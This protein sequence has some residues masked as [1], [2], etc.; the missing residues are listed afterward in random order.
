M[1]NESNPRVSIIIPVYNGSDYLREAI[2]SA[3]GQ[4]YRNI[5]V[6]VINDGSC[7]KG[8][9]EALAKSFG[10][11]IKYIYKENGGVAT[12]LN[13]G[14]VAAQ[15][16]YISWLSHD[17]VYMPNKVELQVALLAESREPVILYSDYYWID[18]A[19]RT[20]GTCRIPR[21]L[22]ELMVQALLTSYPVNGCTTLIPRSCF[23]AEGLFNDTL[24]TTQDYEM[25]FRLARRFKFIHLPYPLLKSRLHAKQGSQTINDVQVSE[26]HGLY[27]WVL[28]NFSPET[29]CGLTQSTL[30]GCYTKLASNFK[31]RSYMNAADRSFDLARRHLKQSKGIRY[32]YD[33]TTI[34]LDTILPKYA[35]FQFWRLVAKAL[36]FKLIQFKALSYKRPALDDRQCGATTD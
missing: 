15:G 25:W 14:I 18:S 16:N 22:P 35:S 28:D 24:R 10:D 27:L 8:R 34:L 33:L 17:D 4:T 29:I 21:I 1:L 30:S 11:K 19:S 2:D 12:A 9:T 3:L 36:S 20:V 26:L 5:E 32:Y 13:T 6:I 7:D 23:D 31:I